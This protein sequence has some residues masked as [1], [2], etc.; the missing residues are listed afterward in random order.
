MEILEEVLLP[1]VQTLLYPDNMPFHL[2][3]DNSPIHT[4]NVVKEWFHDHPFITLVPHPPKSPD[5]NPIENVWAE[6]VKR[7]HVHDIPDRSRAQVIAHTRTAWEDMRGPGGQ[8]FIQT[9]CE[10]MPRRLN[11]VLAAGGSYT[12]Y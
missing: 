6:V 9:V 2:L 5:L 10:S 8:A 1:S 4:S 3:Q 11:C 12:H 7:S